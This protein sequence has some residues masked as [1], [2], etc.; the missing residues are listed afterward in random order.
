MLPG[1]E[2][3]LEYATDVDVDS[4]LFVNVSVVALPTKVSV[5]V[6]RV[7]VPVFEIVEITGDV[8][9]LFVRVC[10]PVNVATVESIAIVTAPEPSNDVPESPVPIVRAFVVEAL[11]V[12]AA[13][14]S[15]ATPLILRA[16][17]SLVAVSAFPVSAPVN[18]V[19]VTD[20]NPAN[21][22]EDAPSD[23][24]VVPTVTAEFES[25]AFAIEPASI[26]FVTVPVSVV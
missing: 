20:V 7:N 5:E 21:V 24:D 23:I 22:V 8:R 19:D 4:V 1:N 26:V 11:I 12:I 10:N 14:P 16:V 25:L 13:E 3:P 15:N 6:G 18:P 9:V 17:A 2:S